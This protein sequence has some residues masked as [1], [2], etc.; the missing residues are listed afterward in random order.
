MLQ[1]I[2]KN[3]SDIII[4]IIF[5]IL[6]F[7]FFNDS[8]KIN[9]LI[10][11][12]GDPNNHTLPIW[13]LIVT[14]IRNG[15]FPFWNR[16]IYSGFPL[17]AIPHS[18][19]L[20]PLLWILYFIFPLSVAYNISILLHYSLAGIFTYIFLNRYKL[21]KLASFCGG[22]VFMFSGLMICHKGHAQMLYT[23]IWFPLILYF[24]DKFRESRRFKFI[25]IGSIFYAFA[26]FAGNNQMFFYGS[27]II[28]LYIIYYSFI[29][30]KRSYYFLYSAAIFIITALIISVQLF[31]AY[32]LVNHSVRS[33]MSF[34]AFS[35]LSY[36]K[37]MILTLISPF[38]Y[39]GGPTGVS[40]FGALS[41]IEIVAYF[42]ITTI[43]FLIIGFFSK[44]RNKY[45][46]IFILIFSFV[47]VLGMNT[48]LYKL[49][50]HIPI[51][52]KLRISPRNWFEFGLAFA[53][54]TGFGFNRFI[55]N[56]N[57]K[58]KILIIA[59][60]SLLGLIGVA[61]G[62]SN[63][64]LKKISNS[65]FPNNFTFLEENLG[66]LLVITELKSYAIYIPI[67]FICILIVL[68]FFSIFK[69]N[70]FIY[71]LLVVLIFF[72]L[73]SFGNYV[74]GSSNASYISK[75]IKVLESYD[76][77]KSET[78]P[79]RVYPVIKWSPDDCMLYP[80]RNIHYEI[81][82]MSGYDP[83]M[84]S[85]YNLFMGMLYM[86]NKEKAGALISNNNILSIL[87]TKYIMYFK[88]ENYDVF[89]K[90]ITKVFYKDNKSIINDNSL[91]SAILK[92]VLNKDKNSF[93][94]QNNDRSLKYFKIPVKIE[95][96]KSYL[97]S[98]EIKENIPKDSKSLIDDKMFVDFFAE[99]YDSAEQEFSL[100]PEDIGTD[101]KVIRKVIFSGGIPADKDIYFRIFTYSNGEIEIKNIELSEVSVSEY[102][103]YEAV[104]NKDILILKNNDYLPRFYFT[105]KVKNI[106]DIYEAYKILWESGVIWEEDRFDPKIETLVEKI[107]FN[108]VEFD[109]SDSKIEIQEYTNNKAKLNITT[110]S[111]E[112]LIFSGTYYPGW[113]AYVDGQ[114]VKIYKVNGLV[115]GIFIPEGEHIVEFNYLPDNFWI[116]FSVS[117]I[118]F[119]SIIISLFIISYRR[120]RRHKL[121]NKI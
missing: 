106:S 49:M 54:L 43:P 91:H 35:F 109:I 114:Q 104:Y 50:Y 112:F 9:T 77:I 8:F 105:E 84:L 33:T 7:I 36:P 26:F 89:L 108:T 90:N 70:K 52:N 12:N 39:G 2:R 42:G 80:N 60:I 101:F 4:I 69:R 98:F 19:I 96:N 64:I 103:N 5:F 57:K 81:D 10:F 120:K 92:G 110:K 72:D 66:S 58:I 97:I 117:I 20:Y 32:E 22:L 76:F 86:D 100:N 24:L 83:A 28:L 82:L 53:V 55:K 71:I 65:S 31:P 1:Q 88:P 18:S 73:R 30:T 93:I 3:K 16:Y 85:D 74:E 118:T 41:Y 37:K 67:V 46:W 61:L 11:G 25:L 99:G 27:M 68:L 63:L 45:F 29:H 40:F 17:F 75:D 79:Y 111:D 121:R 34:G 119:I 14:S 47:L 21:D 38:I 116:Y 62:F 115:M 15:E 102:N 95:K 94:F 6:P 23:V 48:P 44:N 78:Q 87:N 113:R 56:F 107:D 59:A 51:Y 13:D